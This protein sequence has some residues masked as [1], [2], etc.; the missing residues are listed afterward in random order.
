MTEMVA[1]AH[2]LPASGYALEVDGRL[3]AEF[4]TRDGAK[5]GAEELKKRFPCFGSE[6]M[7]RKQRHGKKSSFREFSFDARAASAVSSSRQP[8][9]IASRPSDFDP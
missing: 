8:S 1:T 4:A 7:T 2:E 5:A 6:F 9:H 3:K